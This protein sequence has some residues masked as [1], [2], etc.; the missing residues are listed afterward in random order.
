[1]KSS[2]NRSLLLVL[3]FAMASPAACRDFSAA[4]KQIKKIQLAGQPQM[5]S[6]AQQ[7]INAKQENDTTNPQ[8]MLQ[9]IKKISSLIDKTLMPQIKTMVKAA[10]S[11][12]R[13][14]EQ[15]TLVNDMLDY[16]GQAKT[17]RE[18]ILKLINEFEQIYNADPDFERELYVVIVHELA[19]L[20]SI[21][22]R[23]NEINTQF[24][25]N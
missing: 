7:L 14:S 12:A 6:D 18:K 21:H 13:S 23:M 17:V 2:F 24:N 4:A 16:E 1:M 10:L 8:L 20:R 15:L 19:C 5:I 3:T 25:G 22:K 11:N 9:Q